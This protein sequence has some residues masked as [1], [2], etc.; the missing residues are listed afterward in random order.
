[1]FLAILGLVFI[2]LMAG[3]SLDNYVVLGLLIVA[4]VPFCGIFALKTGKT[5]WILL[6]FLAGGVYIMC[7]FGNLGN[8]LVQ[9]F[10][11]INIFTLAV[12]F[13]ACG[14]HHRKETYE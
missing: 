7:A 13:S 6:T 3:N 11:G 8:T 10:T 12:L 2:S 9:V 5:T 1:V 14:K 4:T